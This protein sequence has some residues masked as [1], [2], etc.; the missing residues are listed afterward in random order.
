VRSLV[1]ALTTAIDVAIGVASVTAAV[2]V[3][4]FTVV[5]LA[6][7]IWRSEPSPRAAITRIRCRW[8]G[9]YLIAQGTVVNFGD[10]DATFDVRPDVEVP[11]RGSLAPREDDFVAVRAGATRTWRWTNGHTGVPSGTAVRRCSA[12]VFF[13]SRGEGDD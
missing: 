9:R 7:H 2:V 13:P 3:I 1:R 8:N 11:G 4:A 12:T 6:L 5:T 10:R